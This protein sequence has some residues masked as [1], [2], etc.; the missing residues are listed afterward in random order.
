M[1]DETN[2]VLRFR[3][4]PSSRDSKNSIECMIYVNHNEYSTLWC[5]VGNRIKIFD[6]ISW[7]YEASDVKLKDKI[8]G[9]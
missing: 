4:N 9:F 6:P 5:A 2:Q 3:I 7:T 8:V 1:F